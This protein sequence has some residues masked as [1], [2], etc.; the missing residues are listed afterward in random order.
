MCS[1][2]ESVFYSCSVECSINVNYVKLV[3]SVT[4]IYIFSTFGLL[5]LSVIRGGV[6]SFSTINVGF[7]KLFSLLSIF[8]LRVLKLFC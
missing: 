7:K 5:I 6:L 1:W 3:G 2:Q 8:A 4:Q